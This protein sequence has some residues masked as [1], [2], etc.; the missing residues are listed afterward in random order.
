MKPTVAVLMTC[1]NRMQK[2]L[3]CMEAL[4]RQT[5]RDKAHLEIF[6]VDDGST[7]G[8][9]AAVSASYPETHVIYG[10]G[11]LFWNRGM[12]RAF[13]ESLEKGF[14][15]YLWLNDDTYLYPDALEKML[16]THASLAEAGSPASIVAASTRDPRTGEFTYGGYR[17]AGWLNPLDLRPIPPEETPI[18]CDAICGNCVLIPKEVVARIGNMD[19][20]YEHRWG[21]V[22]YGL[23][24]RAAGCE[25]WM[26]PGYLADCEGNPK[27]DR[28]RDRS[29]PLRMRFKEL[30]S[31]K[32]VGKRDWVRYVRKHGGAFWPFIWVRPYLRI[33]I[34]TFR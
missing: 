19:P 30:H 18:R 23:R 2:T 3:A 24:A 29:L 20:H 25:L 13:A 22:D 14:D 11:T 9:G 1:H 10:D 5:A 32:G 34:D 4:F 31:L 27:A 33:I 15:Y 17:R 26:G 12:Y 7:D 28:W 21:D 6:L 8:T 16:A